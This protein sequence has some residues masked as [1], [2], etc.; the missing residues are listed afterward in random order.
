MA[1]TKKDH[2]PAHQ[3]RIAAI[4]KALSHPARIALVSEL[5]S[6]NA[7]V[8]GD[9]VAELPLSQ[10]TVSQHLKVLKEADIISGETDGPRVCYCINWTSLTQIRQDLDAW[11]E[12]LTEHQECC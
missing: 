4:A 9:L 10:A 2:F 12:T 3:Q 8:C 6:Q 7:C 1:I 5:A 11:L